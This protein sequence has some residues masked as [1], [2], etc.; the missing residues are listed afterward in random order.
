LVTI[1]LQSGGSR[2]NF[3]TSIALNL[4]FIG[5]LITLGIQHDKTVAQCN[6]IIPKYNLYWE[7]EQ[8]GFCTTNLSIIRPKNPFDMDSYQNLTIISGDMNDG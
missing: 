6:A 8:H 5:A 3:L 2:M 7:S 1:E 4:L